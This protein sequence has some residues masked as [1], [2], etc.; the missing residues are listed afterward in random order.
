MYKLMLFLFL[1]ASFALAC[2]STPQK[3]ADPAPDAPKTRLTVE[4]VREM[5]DNVARSERV[6]LQNYEEPQVFYEET[7]GSWSVLYIRVQPG[8]Q[9]EDFTIVVSDETGECTIIRG[10]E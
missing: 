7:H 3:Q 5:A 9:G 8:P 4:E 10:N 6:F 2:S 1:M